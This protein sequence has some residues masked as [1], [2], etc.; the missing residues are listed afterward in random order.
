MEGYENEDPSKYFEGIANYGY[1]NGKLLPETVYF[2]VIDLGDTDVD[3]NAVDED[4]RYRKGIV[5]IR[6]WNE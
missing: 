6:R 1:T 4:N 2:Y 3:G 5:Y